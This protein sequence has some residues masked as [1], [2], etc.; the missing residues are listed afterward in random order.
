[1]Y[2]KSTA[3]EDIALMMQRALNLEALL[4]DRI[5]KKARI[6]AYVSYRKYSQ[7]NPLSQRM[8][9]MLLRIAYVVGTARDNLYLPKAA[10]G[11]RGGVPLEYRIAHGVVQHMSFLRSSPGHQPFLSFKG[12][13][14]FKTSSGSIV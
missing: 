13:S 3:R 10:P 9:S 6:K 5:G 11:A 14:F 7:D 12:N 8:Q 1:M 4:P 2:R